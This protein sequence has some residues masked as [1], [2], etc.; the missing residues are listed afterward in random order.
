MFCTY[1]H[2]AYTAMGHLKI[3]FILT[4]AVA[5]PAFTAKSNPSTPP[6]RL[7]AFKRAKSLDNGITISWFEQTW[8]KEVLAKNPLKTA[9]FELLKQLGFKSLR[10]P[11]AFAHFEREGIPVEQIFSHIDNFV[12]QCRHYGFKIVLDYH[13]GNLN[14]TNYAAQTSKLIDLW[15]KLTKRY[16][17][18]N[19]D[20]LFFELYNEP[21]QRTHQS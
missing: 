11:I 3:V 5:M 15:T 12:K 21:P 2:L 19:H 16:A 7:T 6:T 18:I 10:L 9:D 1:K 17:H 20:E 8:N 13:G 14:D 4:L